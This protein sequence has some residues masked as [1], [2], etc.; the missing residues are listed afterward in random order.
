VARLQMGRK[1][2][3][4]GDAGD[5]NTVYEGQGDPLLVALFQEDADGARVLIENNL[6]NIEAIDQVGWR[7]LH[8]ACFAGLRNIVSLLLERGA[9]PTALDG[10]GC[11]PLHVAASM[12]DPDCCKLL[13]EARADPTQPD[14]YTGMTPQIYAVSKEEGLAQQLGQILGTV[15]Q[16]ALVAWSNPGEISRLNA[17]A[18][19]ED[20]R[21]ALQ[22]K[23]I[24]DLDKPKECCDEPQCFK[25][26]VLKTYTWDRTS[27][28][29][30]E[31]DNDDDGLETTTESLGFWETAMQNFPDLEDRLW[32]QDW[33]KPV[34]QCCSDCTLDVDDLNEGF[35]LTFHF[36]ENP[37]FTNNKLEKSYHNFK[38]SPGTVKSDAMEI[39]STEIDWKPGRDVTVEKVKDSED[40]Q[41]RFSFFRNFFCRLKQGG[42]F[43]DQFD[44]DNVRKMTGMDNREQMMEM[45]MGM[46]YDLGCALRDQLVPFAASARQGAA[47]TEAGRCVRAQA[48]GR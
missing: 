18:E 17:T 19:T 12:G 2:R 32:V 46:E 34:L 38:S 42:P 24:A 23:F 39:Q 5:E 33:D 29:S 10:Q 11:G 43:P 30:D 27:K 20:E 1:R 6:C 15:D 28:A 3:A 41:P 47:S 21:T 16:K 31:E 7:P 26:R 36:L 13:V 4:L 8:R 44:E 14:Q 22:E 35:T 25:P 45:L 48:V 37:Y 9:D 40:E